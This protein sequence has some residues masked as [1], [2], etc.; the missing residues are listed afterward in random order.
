VGIEDFLIFSALWHGMINRYIL[1]VVFTVFGRVATPKTSDSRN[2]A[3]FSPDLFCFGMGSATD[4][5]L[6]HYQRDRF[7]DCQCQANASNPL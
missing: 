4:D 5:S 6:E 2:P 7:H 3:I 1:N